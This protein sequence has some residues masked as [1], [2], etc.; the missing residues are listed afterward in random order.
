MD[1]VKRIVMIAI[2]GGPIS[3]LEARELPALK[4]Q[5]QQDLEMKKLSVPISIQDMAYDE[6]AWDY[7]IRTGG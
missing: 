2:E 4:Q 7:A 1:W 3:Q 6:F 5:V